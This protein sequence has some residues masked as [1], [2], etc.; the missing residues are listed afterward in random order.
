MKPRF[1][2]MSL[3]AI[4]LMATISALGQGCT[5][6]IT[7]DWESTLPGR[8][9]ANLYHFAPDGTITVFSVAQPRQELARGSYNL[10]STSAPKT[11][12]LKQLRGQDVF[13]GSGARM[14]ITRFDNAGFSVKSGTEAISWRRK[15]PFKYFVV[16]AAH[17]GTP[18][19]KGGPAFGMLIK[20]GGNKTEAESFGLYYLDD[21]RTYGPVSEEL[22]RQY[23]AGSRSDQDAVLRL[24]ITAEDFARSMRVVKR[25]QKR[26]HDGALLYP[27]H[28]YLNIIIPLKEI[29]ESQNQCGENINLYKL[30]WMMDDEL[31]AKVPEWELA[32]QYVKKLRQL[33]ESL[34]VT[35]EKFQQSIGNLEHS[36]LSAK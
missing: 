10:D 12:E 23:M 11:I 22:F 9:S 29:A 4:V 25:W 34:H 17:R 14:E 3:L 6:S 32:F 35:D 18:P 15:D 30:R 5:I 16:L 1:L 8:M 31:G 33:N 21:H 26:A 7:G 36:Q 27:S 20:S 13:P 28:S 19:H 2:F 24:Q